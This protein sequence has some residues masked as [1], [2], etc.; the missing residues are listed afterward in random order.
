MVVPKGIDDRVGIPDDEKDRGAVAQAIQDVIEWLKILAPAVLRHVAGDGHQVKPF[1]ADRLQKPL[2]VSPEGFFVQ[3]GQLQNGEAVERLRKVFDEDRLAPHHDPLVVVHGVEN[4]GKENCACGEQDAQ[5]SAFACHGRPILSLTF[6]DC[7]R[8]FLGANV[9][10]E[11]FP[12][13]SDRREKR[14]YPVIAPVSTQNPVVMPRATKS[15]HCKS[16]SGKPFSL[17]PNSG[18]R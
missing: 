9:T 4:Q 17:A 5:P 18:R 3:I 11:V 2:L 15:P 13:Y 12:F 7:R 14:K 6:S 16:A 1:A 8:N 10:E